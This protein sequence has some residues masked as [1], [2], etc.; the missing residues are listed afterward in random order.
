M[1]QSDARFLAPQARRAVWT[2]AGTLSEV[3]DVAEAWL[4]RPALADVLQAAGGPRPCGLAG[5]APLEAWTATHFDRRRGKER[6]EAVAEPLGDLVERALLDA[7]GPLGLLGTAGPRHG[8]YDLVIVLGGTVTGNRLR[9]AHTAALSHTVRLGR[10]VGVSGARALT[11][12]ELRDEPAAAADLDEATHLRRVFGEAATAV[13]ASPATARTLAEAAVLT[14]PPAL[15][16]GR[17]GTAEGIRQLTGAVPAAARR[18]VLVVTS[19]IYVP[20][21]FFVAAPILIAAG[22]G[23]VELVGTP[24]VVDDARTAARRFA[25]ELHSAVRALAALPAG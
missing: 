15:D 14:A 12:N 8:R 5:I 24:T 4:A 22:T 25:Q 6:H 1:E 10:V 13:A 2:A 16:G 9:V 3:R 11:P 18:R 20:Y 23:D 7:A 21:Q 19:A 17:A